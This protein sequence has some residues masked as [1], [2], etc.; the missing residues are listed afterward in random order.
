M[1]EKKNQCTCNTSET[2]IVFACS[3]A[4]DLGMITDLV[5]K[6]LHIAGKRKMNCLAVVG[7]GIK[8]SIDQ[9]KSKDVLVIDGCSIACGKRMM[10]HHGFV[11]Y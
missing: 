8:K 4:S 5:S 9:F 11:D 6:R 10:E 7:A 1:N 3:G 2:K